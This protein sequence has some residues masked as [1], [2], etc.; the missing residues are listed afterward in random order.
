M[1]TYEVSPKLDKLISFKKIFPYH[2]TSTWIVAAMGI[3]SYLAE[4]KSQKLL[5]WKQRFRC[6]LRKRYSENM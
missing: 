1:D 2:A 3:Y 6:V 5:L 4:K